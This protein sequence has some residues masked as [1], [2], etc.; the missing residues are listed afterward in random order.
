MSELRKRT[1]TD[2][3]PKDASAKETGETTNVVDSDD[4]KFPEESQ[5]DALT[6]DLPQASD[7]TNACLDNVLSSLP[8]RFVDL[9]IS[10]L[11]TELRG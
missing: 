10:C 4:E 2:G 11:F 9:F 3:E 5:V 8:K 6:K 1:T 7:E